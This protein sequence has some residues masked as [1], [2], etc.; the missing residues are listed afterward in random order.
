[1]STKGRL[2][3]KPQKKSIEQQFD[4][5][6]VEFVYNI[7]P[8]TPEMTISDG[9]PGSVTSSGGGGTAAQP[10]GV[11]QNRDE[12]SSL[13]ESGCVVPT[14]PPWYRRFERKQLKEQLIKE[15]LDAY[16]KPVM[17]PN[18]KEYYRP[19][20]KD[21]HEYANLLQAMPIKKLLSMGH[22]V[23]YKLKLDWF[24]RLKSLKK[25]EH[26]VV[27]I[28][29]D[30]KTTDTGVIHCYDRT[31]SRHDMSYIVMSDR[32]VYDPEFKMA[33]FYYYANQP[34]P[35]LYQKPKMPEGQI[36]SRLMDD[37]IEM[38]VIEALAAVNIDLLIKVCL[39]LG[40]LNM[41]M[42]GIG[43]AILMKSS[44]VIG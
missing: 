6:P 8:P 23:K 2:F 12:K 38:K 26:A 16:A 29:N 43:L 3:S 1:M 13:V 42:S 37:I 27:T 32:G 25:K 30:N 44:G 15:L 36:D 34:F 35:L 24:D 5:Q 40:A 20:E 18:T 14:I 33:H 28:F 10:Q 19:A 7:P 22:L 11:V 17:I 21:I 9:A 31:F 39:V 41:V 4:E